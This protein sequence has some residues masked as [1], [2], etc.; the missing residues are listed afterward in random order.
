ME[1]LGSQ[2][3]QY[4]EGNECC[5]HHRVW[6]QADRTPDKTAVVC[7]Q[8]SLTY[9]ALRL[10]AQELAQTLQASGVKTGTRV[11]VGLD[12]SLAMAVAVLGILEAGGA[13]VPLDARYPTERLEFVI[14]DA[15]VELLLSQETWRSRLPSSDLPTVWL[16]SHDAWELDVQSQLSTPRA[17]SYL[18]PP[19]PQDPAYMIYTSG[20]TGRPKGVLIQHWTADN[21]VQS[22]AKRPGLEASDITIAVASLAFDMSV[23][24]LFL[25]W[26]VGATVNLI[27]QSVLADGHQLIQAIDDASATFVQA[28]P[29]LFRML[30]DANWKPKRAP[31][32]VMGGEPVSQNLAEALLALGCKVW[33]GYGTTE[34]SIYS[35][36][37]QITDATVPITVGHAVDRTYLY[38]LDSEGIPVTHDQEGEIVIGG[39]GVSQGYWKRDALTEE[40]FGPDTQATE[41]EARW[42]RTGDRGRWSSD[43]ELVCLGRLDDQVKIRGFRV[44]LGE[45]EAALQSIEGVQEASV[46]FRRPTSNHAH[47]TEGR[48]VGY[49][50]LS[51]DSN[52]L[53]RTNEKLHKALQEQLSTFL[54]PYMIPTRFHALPS[55]PISTAGKVDRK[56]LALLDDEAMAN[57]STRTKAA[58]SLEQTLCDWFAELL[59]YPNVGPEQD[60]LRLGGHSLLAT[61]LS[62]RIRET[63]QVNVSAVTVLTERTPSKLAASIEAKQ[64]GSDNS[65]SPILR[66]DR[67]Q[68]LPLSSTEQ[69]LW[70]L[71]QLAP[72][73][74]DYNIS[75]QLHF[76]GE[77]NHSALQQAL[78][79]LVVQHEILR[80]TFVRHEGQAKQVITEPSSL[81]LPK[82]SILEVPPS[83]REA[84][85]E[86]H[87]Q[88]WFRQTFDLEKGPLWRAQLLKVTEQH[89]IL[90]CSLHHIITDGWSDQVFFRSLLDLYH[91]AQQNALSSVEPLPLQTVDAVVWQHNRLQGKFLEQ[92]LHYWSQLLDGA[93]SRLAMPLDFPRPKKRS[94]EARDVHFEIPPTLAERLQA[95]SEEQGATL[96]MTLLSTFATLLMQETE[97]TDIPLGT[98]IAN[99]AHHDMTGMI[100]FF[101]NTVVF[102]V[103]PTY[104]RTFRELVQHTREQALASYNHQELPFDRLVQELRPPRTPDH[105]PLFQV[106][107]VQQEH[108]RD[109]YEVPSLKGSLVEVTHGTSPFDL[110]VQFWKE[111]DS[112]QG[113]LS[114]RTDL[115]K[116]STIQSL[117]ERF[118]HVAEDVL[119][120]PDR[121]LGTWRSPQIVASEQALLATPGIHDVAVVRRPGP[122]DELLTLA[123]AV[124]HHDA[125]WKRWQAQ[126]PSL[127]EKLLSPTHWIRVA[128]IPRDNNGLVKREAL[129]QIP[130]L[131]DVQRQT[132]TDTL[133]ANEQVNDAEVKR[134]IWN[135]STPAL[136][137]SLLLPIEEAKQPRQ[138][139]LE[140][141]S[142][143]ARPEQQVE[144]GGNLSLREGPPL[145]FPDTAPQSLPAILR[146][147][148]E[149]VP[150]KGV[151]NLDMQ[152]KEH[153][154]SYPSL[155]K[156]A[157]AIATGLLDEGLKPGDIVI[158]QL[159]NNWDFVPALWACFLSGV[160]VVP[161]ATPP[162]YA[163]TNAPLEKLAQVWEMLHHP[164]VIASSDTASGIERL[165]QARQW[166]T[167]M[168][169]LLLPG[170]RETTPDP[171]RFEASPDPNAVVLMLLTSGSTGLPKAVTHHHRT[172]CSFLEMYK[173]RHGFHN[174]EVFLNWLGLDH[175]AP[176]F[177]CHLSAVYNEGESVNAPFASFKQQPAVALDWVDCYRGTSTF[178]PN[179][180]FGLINEQEEAIAA[181]E[182][183]LSS[184]RVVTNGGEMI[185]AETARRFLE[186]LIPHGLPEE[187]MVPIWGMSE[188]SSATITWLDFR[189]D[190]VSNDD[191]FVPI[192]DPVPGFGMRIVDDQLQVTPEG[193]EGRLQVRGPCCLSEYYNRPDANAE[194][195]TE[196]GWFDTGDLAFID[197]RGMTMTGRL[198]D[199]I[200]IMGTNYYNH[201]I[202]AVVES[203]E[204]VQK[205]FAVAC[206]VRPKGA[207]TDQVAIFFSPTPAHE[208][209]SLLAQTLRQI[210]SAV[211]RQVGLTPTVILP[212]EPALI[213]KTEIG[214]IQR[215]K[216]Q[217]LYTAGLFDTLSQDMDILLRNERTL[218]PWFVQR[219]WK[220][221]P[222]SSATQLVSEASPL[223][224][225][226]AHSDANSAQI[227]SLQDAGTSVVW[228]TKEASPS[229]QHMDWLAPNAM[230][231]WVEERSRP[232]AVFHAFALDAPDATDSSKDGLR[233]AQQLGVYSI[234]SLL[235]SLQKKWRPTAE[236]PIRV[237]VATPPVQPTKANEAVEWQWSALVGLLAAV[238]H[239]MPGLVI[240]HVEVTDKS[241]W[242]SIL[243]KEQHDPRPHR[244]EV[245]WVGGQRYEPRLEL[246]DWD[247]LAKQSL[248]WLPGDMVVVTGGLGG[249]GSALVQQ[250]LREVGVKALLVG[251]TPLPS[252]EE[253]SQQTE[254]QTERWNE[255]QA[256]Q[257]ACRQ[258]SHSSAAVEYVALDIGE[259]NA[260][261]DAVAHWE[262][263]WGQP[264]R[265]VFH[266]AGTLRDVLLSRE[267]PEGMDA[268]F[269]ARL[270]GSWELASLVQQRPDSF[271]IDFG[272]INEWMGG[273]SAGTYAAGGRVGEGLCQTLRAQG[274]K[275]YHILWSR[276]D[277]VGMTRDLLVGNQT[278]ARGFLS[279]SLEQ[280]LSSLLA[281]LS[282]PPGNYCV[283]LDVDH[284]H[285]R[286][287]L[288][289]GPLQREQWEASVVLESNE[290]LGSLTEAHPNDLFGQSVPIQ[291]NVVEALTSSRP[292]ATHHRSKGST[293]QL[294]PLQ[295]QLVVA[296][297]ELLVLDQVGLDDNF[298][299]LGG[300][301][302]LLAQLQE[303]LEHDLRRP[304]NIVDFFAHP[305]IRA[306]ADSLSQEAKSQSKLADV[307]QESVTSRES[308]E[309]K[310]LESKAPPKDEK[311]PE[312]STPSVEASL[313]KPDLSRAQQRK[314]AQQRR[315]AKRRK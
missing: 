113:S 122:G 41:T 232:S 266:L 76:R 35:C 62:S 197:Q 117:A 212:V 49:A 252:G 265:G 65:L 119:H 257:A 199:V 148:A 251:R 98:F 160:V 56:A 95:F 173:Q 168:R 156:E 200:I 208:E 149:R 313:S 310:P 162:T 298:F 179:S 305:T 144:H 85:I 72:N 303:R 92:S 281:C 233:K 253:K 71:N 70:F 124:V 107:V 193:V 214:K 118:Q 69:R 247:S 10:H 235:Q 280:G 83:E 210:R 243:Q 250:L 77:L 78:D 159:P 29:S 209:P 267:T 206:A 120:E 289:Q 22:F 131:S 184:F 106:C 297:E 53:K 61:R 25:A 230:Q 97:Q 239:E 221:A 174:D 145:V 255:W 38:V 194:S 311:P 300:H 169:P 31:K 21:V 54:P 263:Q 188:T 40:R 272:T 114:Y 284:P 285:V 45:I 28:T 152:G 44:E 286:A 130:L 128:R 302:M 276:W 242:L 141:A 135:T 110:F 189:L 116:E 18:Q 5:L 192:G 58:T 181:G 268:V 34:T 51:P 186:L 87:S 104:E 79:A 60:F 48:L 187:A 228:G 75:L 3:A 14:N 163:N 42:Y 129:W 64:S 167:P 151:T 278:Q 133:K 147:A 19:T 43:G 108:L 39:V 89:N 172:I 50:V 170:L 150:H 213:P 23:M 224:V 12:R 296:W 47:D 161:M 254:R 171:S 1:I 226:S 46:L 125:T 101:A 132:F 245:A 283:G 191:A 4:H 6:K 269:S 204:G 166:D 94:V 195:F 203:V 246:I 88:R 271:F 249:I 123:Y 260:V 99:R 287:M 57:E 301:S 215:S 277:R 16:Q 223:W 177:M 138:E 207:N 216:I 20:S 26:S 282:R 256:L 190:T 304:I 164:P 126:P 90:L 93:P 140:K 306:F 299:D 294:T 139:S 17:E 7:G 2:Q 202:E 137:R 84:A 238:P 231:T 182:W 165:S 307:S 205:T 218:P 74:L 24:D 155:L 196:D 295:K 217:K 237:Y 30:L 198:K 86:E 136:H 143:E 8:E 109:D 314:L 227:Q 312:E 262:Q 201:E 158:L 234:L 291:W 270:W 264:L 180:A 157:E 220:P 154:L 308:Q 225:F 219:V 103:Q 183:D 274:V 36:I 142:T 73:N 290:A 11:A 66:A 229:S 96:Y 261:A 222:L 81:S 15:E 288:T 176:L 134:T 55:L 279:I 37:K 111:G 68:A 127:P 175:V 273:F 240:R 146:N 248:P 315:A 153:I 115:Y 112:L 63:Y 178:L 33:N 91:Q 244:N 82:A 185:V 105:Q 121:S 259:P 293:T 67:S 9:D 27:P 13:Y 52:G 211:T 309:P 32:V 275:A 100:G 258:S 80:T 102:R 241:S 236:N 59:E 292:T